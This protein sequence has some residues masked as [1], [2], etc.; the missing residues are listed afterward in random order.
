MGDQNQNLHLKKNLILHF[1]YGHPEVDAHLAASNRL[2]NETPAQILASNVRRR[3]PEIPASPVD[4]EDDI[5]ATEASPDQHSPV[6][7]NRKL[8]SK[9]T[10]ELSKLESTIRTKI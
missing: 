3:H 6:T 10:T 1:S 9:S 2:R 4:S 5:P 8:I 7:L